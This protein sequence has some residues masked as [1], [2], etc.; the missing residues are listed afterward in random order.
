MTVVVFGGDLLLLFALIRINAEKGVGL[1]PAPFLRCIADA[2][3]SAY[4]L[5][6]ARRATPTT[7]FAWQFYLI[8]VG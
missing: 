3:T 7:T 4:R 2:L 8:K 1:A 6:A 5:S